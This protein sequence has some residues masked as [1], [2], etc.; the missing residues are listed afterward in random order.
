L[1][2]SVNSSVPSVVN[3]LFVLF[4][5]FVVSLLLLFPYSPCLGKMIELEPDAG[6]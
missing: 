6:V 2:F 3:L 5:R 4:V 1:F